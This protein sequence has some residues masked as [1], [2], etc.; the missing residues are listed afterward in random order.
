MNLEFSVNSSK[1]NDPST[2]AN[3]WIIILQHRLV[4]KTER[5]SK[6]NY[7]TPP[8]QNCWTHAHTQRRVLAI[9][10]AAL[11]ILY[12]FTHT[13][14]FDHQ[15]GPLWWPFWVSPLLPWSTPCNRNH[16]SLSL[17]DEPSLTFISLIHTTIKF[18]GLSNHLGACKTHAYL[19]FI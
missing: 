1:S 5:R 11:M 3:R 16:S 4:T 10:F 8:S 18:Q 2:W 13:R 15:V 9:P 17:R 14:C 12:C 7:H 6:V 19:L